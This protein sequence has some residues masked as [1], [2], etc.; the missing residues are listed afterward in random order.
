MTLTLQVAARVDEAS[1]IAG[2]VLT[3]PQ[4]R[5]L[6]SWT[7]GAHIDVHIDRV[8]QAPIV[9]QYSLCGDPADLSSYRIAFND[10]I[11]KEIEGI[12]GTDTVKAEV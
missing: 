12:L 9:R 6:P 8:G 5:S 7:P 4:G 2:L 11:A 1:G 3:D 10:L